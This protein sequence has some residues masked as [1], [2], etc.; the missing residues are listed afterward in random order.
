MEEFEM[1]VEESVQESIA[2]MYERENENLSATSSLQ[3]TPWREDV[4]QPIL[5]RILEKEVQQPLLP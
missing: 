3:F 2:R 4:H 1:K 5:D